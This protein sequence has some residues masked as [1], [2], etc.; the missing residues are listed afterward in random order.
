MI[1]LRSVELTGAVD[2]SHFP[3]ALPAL[4]EFERIELTAPVTFLVGENGSGKSTFIEALALRAKLPPATGMPLEHDPTL[5]PV[6]PLALAFRL[7]W[8]P[9]TKFGFFLRAEDFFNFARE[10]RDRVES[11]EAMATRFGDDPRVRGYMYAQKN[12]LTERYGEDLH[13]LSHGESFLKFFQTRCVAGGLHLIDEPEAALSPQR[14]LAFLS[15][16]K[17]LVAAEAQFIIAT[18]SPILLAFPE[19][20][21]LCFD[22]GAVRTVEY[23][24]LPNVTIT[25]SFLNDP[26]AFIRQL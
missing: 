13:A 6:H 4:R 14:Q 23:E 3:F 25:R 1:F 17:Q 16:L 9:R 15:L 19:A 12:A 21:I 20:Q 24:E 7:G 11:M 18:H 10:T 5:A 8:K 22:D 2:R 26:E